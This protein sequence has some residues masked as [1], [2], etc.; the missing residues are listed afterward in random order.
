MGND[1]STAEPVG[2]EAIDLA[3]ENVR[4]GGRPFG[5]F[6]RSALHAN[7]QGILGHSLVRQKGCR[8]VIENAASQEPPASDAEG[9][10]SL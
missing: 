3:R 2:R 8:F 10:N 7:S 4:N 1:M 5:V 6:L 9:R